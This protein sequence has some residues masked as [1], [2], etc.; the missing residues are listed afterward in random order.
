MSPSNDPNDPCRVTPV[1]LVETEEEKN[2]AIIKWIKSQLNHH[3]DYVLYLQ[4]KTKLQT[5][6]EVLNQ[7]KIVS[8]MLGLLSGLVI[9]I[10]FQSQL[11]SNLGLPD[12]SLGIDATPDLVRPSPAP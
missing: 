2:D 3:P 11:R 9:S 10:L 5:V 12:L 6:P 1:R 4:S 8:R 7:Y